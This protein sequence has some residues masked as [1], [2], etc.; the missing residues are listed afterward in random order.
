MEKP[1]WRKDKYK[2]RS[3]KTEKYNMWNEIKAQ[4]GTAE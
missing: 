4:L 1:E 2:K 3:S